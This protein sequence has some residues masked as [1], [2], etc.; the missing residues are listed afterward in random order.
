[1]A[2]APR[3]ITTAVPGNTPGG[4]NTPAPPAPQVPEP[5]SAPSPTA[6]ESSRP[7]AAYIDPEKITRAVL[8]KQ[9][10]VVPSK[11]K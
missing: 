3:T 11:G 1:M 9:G 5:P 10:W 2:R 7:D 6:S 8:T 4:D